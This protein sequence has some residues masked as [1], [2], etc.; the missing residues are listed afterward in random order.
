MPLSRRLAAAQT[1]PVAGDVA[2]NVAQHVRLAER[3]ADARASVVV[4]PELSLTGYELPLGPALAFSCSRADPRASTNPHDPRLA[5]LIE[6][7]RSRALTLVVGAPV[8]IDTG[9]HIGAF[10]IGPAGAVAI[11]TKRHLSGFDSGAN[12]G[13]PLPPAEDSVFTPGTLCPRVDLGDHG[14]VVAICAESFQR[15]V[16]KD[17]NERG[18]ETYLTSHFSLPRDRALRIAGLAKFAAHARVA[19]VFSN[20]GGPSA[21]LPASGG[22]AILSPSGE[23]LCE[24]GQH[25]A[26][27]AVA[28][29]HESGWQTEC[30]Q[31]EQG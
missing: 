17:A 22:S 12:L 2:A 7:A 16:M 13:G 18:A 30:V 28:R 24:L 8:R 21:G 11:H 9:L 20:Y 5:P 10:I 29:E 19:V 26:G 27:L 1:V 6:V 23:L 25:G 3:A 31:V 15:G 4:F 14:A